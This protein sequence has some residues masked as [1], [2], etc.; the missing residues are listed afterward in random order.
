MARNPDIPAPMLLT[1]LARDNRQMGIRLAQ[2]EF[3][4]M[5]T[6]LDNPSL[7]DL[8]IDFPGESRPHTPP[9]AS[10]LDE[11]ILRRLP[12]LNVPLGKIAWIQEPEAL[13]AIA[14]L[15]RDIDHRILAKALLDLMQAHHARPFARLV[16]VCA[17]LRPIPF[18]GR[19]GFAYEYLGDQNIA[20][21]G[22]RLA[23]RYGIDEVRDLVDGEVI[24][25]RSTDA[26]AA[27]LEISE[28]NE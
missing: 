24:W 28:N 14:I 23:A 12:V 5:R 4:E 16:F 2:L 26:E 13:P 25:R 7:F 3:R 17:S 27:A 19:Y 20:S 1:R 8:K 9:F 21:A 15:C 22:H 6:E 11:Q 18:L 10:A